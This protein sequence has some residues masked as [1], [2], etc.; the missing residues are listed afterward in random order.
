MIIEKIDI[1]S[2]GVLTDLAL[3]FSDTVNVIEGQ[4]EAGKSTIA[5]FIKYMLFGFESVESD[6]TLGERKKRINWNTGVAQGSMIV[7]VKGKRYLVSR[8]TVYGE[9]VGDR[10]TYKEDSSI[11]DMETGA[12]AFGKFPAGEVFFGVSRELYENTAF[13]GQIGDAAINEGSVKESIEN[14]LFSASEKMN[15]QRALALVGDKMEGL[16]NRTGHGGAIYDLVTKRDDLEERFKKSKED[17]KQILAK[18]AELHRI[19]TDRAEAENMLN[20]LHELDSCY[21]NV[22]LIQTFEKLHELEEDAEAKAAAY[23]AFIEENTHA[24][25]VPS[26]AYLSELGAARRAVN[27]TY[28]ALRDAEDKY[29]KEKN[30]I[31][32]THE[33]ENAI[34]VADRHGGESRAEARADRAKRRI[35]SGIALSV[36][37][38]LLA[39]AAVVTEIVAVGVLAGIAFRILFGAVGAAA[40]AGTVYFILD[41]LKA[42]GALESLC[43]DFGVNSYADLKG[44]LG[45]I[46][47]AREKRDG[48]ARSTEEARLAKEAAS[49]AYDEAKAEL[50]RVIVRWGEEPPT[51]ELNL[52]LDRLEAR[53]LAFLERKR[54]LLEEKNTAE[55]TVREIRSTLSDKNEI[56]IRAQ[57]SPI[58]RKALAT[59]NHDEIITGIAAFKAKIIEVDKLAY[60]VEN[61]LIALKARAGDPGELYAKMAVLDAR[62][63]ELK[64]KHKAYFIAHKSIESA[65]DDLR[66]EISPRLGEYATMLMSIMTD[67]KYCEFDVSDGLKVSFLAEDGEK[68]TVDFLS[69]GTRDLAYI[70]VRMALIDMLFD[71]KPPVIFDESFAHQ[72]NLRA[73]SM[74]KAIA[75]LAEDGQQSFIFT[76]R[77]REAALATELVNGAGVFTLSVTSSDIA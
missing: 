9:P 28:Y 35:A 18:E 42:K 77:A 57:V 2:F 50:T 47:E 38:A 1:R 48:M 44:K 64:A 3:E 29:T 67:K 70:A 22:M 59:I 11:I 25:Y 43:S 32:I 66:D 6:V 20:K 31:G 34:E 30:A 61:E 56:D 49:V 15:N 5:A 24:G 39:L 52:F 71:E 53:V 10:P 19:K 40:V 33:I 68:R 76:C 54:L 37:T 26:E 14:I 51:S 21:K 17:N 12:T 36:I 75:R 7:R 8:S 72:D 60:G 55:L 4:N 65:S 45:I 13:V 73:R 58:K 74:M 41:M 23:N 16:F 63:A 27:D 62:I 69:G 46:A